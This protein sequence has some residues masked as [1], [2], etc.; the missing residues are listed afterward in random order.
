M[1]VCANEQ[2]I[3]NLYPTLGKLASAISKVVSAQQHDLVD[4]LSKRVLDNHTVLD[5]L[6]AEEGSGLCDSQHLLVARGR[7]KNTIA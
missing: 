2:M 6:L 1:G 4:S 3:R 5:Y 7:S